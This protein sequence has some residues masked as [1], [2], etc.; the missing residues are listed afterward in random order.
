MSPL[1]TAALIV[2]ALL[3]QLH[4]FSTFSFDGAR[5]EIV[6]ALVLVVGYLVG[7][8][9]GAIVGFAA[10]LAFD[11][12]V[13]TPFGLTAFVYTLAG[14]TMGRLTPGLVRSAAWIG[15]V[16][17]AVGSMA[18]MIGYALIGAVLGVDTLHGPPLG[19]LLVMV[20]LVNLVFALPIIWL[21]RWAR[22]G[23]RTRRRNS[24]FA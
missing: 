12:Y 23:D 9:E 17:V 20:G 13:A 16:A 24:L 21:V 11:V 14:Y 22:T 18:T 3:L 7:P 15:A 5:P 2:G 19:T 8:D 10:G 1:R 6:I 4:L